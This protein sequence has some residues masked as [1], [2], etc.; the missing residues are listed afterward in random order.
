ML[1]RIGNTIPRDVIAAGKGKYDPAVK[2]MK[3]EKA[4][5][6]FEAL[7]VYQ[8]LKTMRTS[9]V[10]N[11]DGEKGFGK[12]IFMSIADEAL[13]DK[14]SESNA[15]GIGKLLLATFDRRESLSDNAVNAE[16]NDS[17]PFVPLKRGRFVPND[18]ESPRVLKLNPDAVM[19]SGSASGKVDLEDLIRSLSE[20]HKLPAGLIDA[21]IQVESAGNRH[22]V[23]NKGAKGLMQLT[24]STAK[25]LGVQDVFDPKENVE[26]GTRYLS[27]LLKRF[28]GD[29]KLALAAYNA[30]PG[31]VDR[32]GGIPPYK[33][34]IRYVDKV[35]SLMH[36]D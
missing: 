19:R 13:A 1:D 8:L 30:G 25:D 3:L 29:L 27:G 4:A 26:G 2:R 24:D 6:D 33:E 7:F 23:S 18:A 5:Y 16:D 10:S 21:V 32:H 11:K 15:L 9:F 28:S 17:Y 20:K 36:K 31:A 35:I 12:D 14:M 22:A 34:T